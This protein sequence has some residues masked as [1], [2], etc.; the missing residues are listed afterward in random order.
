[1]RGFSDFTTFSLSV[2]L[3]LLPTTTYA[4]NDNTQNLAYISGKS[5]WA[6]HAPAWW[7]EWNS[8]HMQQWHKQ[9]LQR[10]FR[11]MNGEIP[12]EY[13]KLI[14]PLKATKENLKAGKALYHNKCVQCHGKSGMGDGEAARNL[15]PSPALL[16]YL[17][18]KPIAADSYLMWTISEGGVEK[19]TDMPA[20]KAIL[21]RE[22]IWK[23]I[24]FMKSNFPESKDKQ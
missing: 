11:F 18:Q 19:Q 15:R 2:L 17:I 12:K 23:I 10:H 4:Q 1:M 5:M 20:F 6:P 14:N 21:S 22:E 8:Q 24:I 16:A 7:E 9:R 13:S 3:F